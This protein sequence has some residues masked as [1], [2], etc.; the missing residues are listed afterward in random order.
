MPKSRG[1]VIDLL[2]Q[3]KSSDTNSADIDELIGSL[4]ALDS[5]SSDQAINSLRGKFKKI[6]A[7]DAS[8]LSN[9]SQDQTDR[10]TGSPSKEHLTLP[11]IAY[12]ALC[13]LA[14]FRPY[15]DTDPVT[16]TNIPDIEETNRI[17]LSTGHVFNLAALIN[18]HNERNYRG[19][20][21]GET[22]TRKYLLNPITNQA[23]IERDVNQI[24]HLAKTKG[25]A[26]KHLKK[27][28]PIPYSLPPVAPPDIPLS[29]RILLSA[30]QYNNMPPAMR[31]VFAAH[32]HEITQLLSQQV[33]METILQLQAEELE[34][35]CQRL[36]GIHAI[37]LAAGISFNDFLQIPSGHK[38]ILIESHYDAATSLLAHIS[39]SDLMQLEPHTL[40]TL[41]DYWYNIDEYV[42]VLKIPLST[43]LSWDTP[44]RN[45]LLQRDDSVYCLIHDCKIPIEQIVNLTPE[46]R[47]TILAFA[48]TI[49]RF[50]KELHYPFADLM[51]LTDATRMQLLRHAADVI[52]LAAH[53]LPLH[54]L[55]QLTYDIR[56]EMLRNT[57]SI[58]TVLN[59]LRVPLLELIELPAPMR[60]ELLSR[61]RDYEILMNQCNLSLTQLSNLPLDVRLDFLDHAPSLATLILANLPVEKIAALDADSRTLLLKQAANASECI[62]KFG[63]RPDTLLK[64]SGSTRNEILTHWEAVRV[65][66]D[67][68]RPFSIEQF[69]AMEPDKRTYLLLHYRDFSDFMTEYNISF[70][71]L[72]SLR[73]NELGIIVANRLDAPETEDLAHII[74]R[75]HTTTNSPK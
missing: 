64:L 72:A 71:S 67:L 6:L 73:K 7:S 16:L 10:Q 49:R 59:T 18:Y 2:K 12:E 30:A 53:N 40:Q 57:R 28:A 44:V 45:T 32:E 21:L 46:T 5:E 4:E 14:K 51:G 66:A 39:F 56:E 43:I 75:R 68:H 60:A 35:I 58:K 31:R 33:P 63:M 69:I 3:I 54:T 36:R 65:F 34:K 42:R 26:I 15:N 47:D 48:S 11:D 8:A 62:K 1:E 22:P 38:I 61:A 19:S 24:I 52:D 13:M 50:I 25:L 9:T 70:D 41:F 74:A 29:L 37:I 27:T 20:A 23:F 55:L 17:Y